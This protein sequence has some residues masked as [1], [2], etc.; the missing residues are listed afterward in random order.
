MAVATNGSKMHGVALGPLNV[1]SARW[2][3]I[4]RYRIQSIY[5]A[6]S[7]IVVKKVLRNHNV[8]HYPNQLVC[9]GT[10]LP[11]WLFQSL[12]FVILSMCWQCISVFLLSECGAI[13]ILQC[14]LTEPLAESTW[15][16]EM[17]ESDCC[18]WAVL[19]SILSNLKTPCHPQQM[20]HN[21]KTKCKWITI[22]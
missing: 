7:Y 10:Y 18:K 15:G 17:L 19:S 20:A 22:W 21:T 16:R 6:P 1:P 13:S 12:S 5:P 9:S 3:Q 14:H 11:A 4:Y 8:F 2:C